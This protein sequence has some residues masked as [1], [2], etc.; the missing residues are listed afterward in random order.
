MAESAKR[1]FFLSGGPLFEISSSIGRIHDLIG[2]AVGSNIMDCKIAARCC[3]LGL[4]LG[5]LI[6]L[7]MRQYSAILTQ[8]MRNGVEKIWIKV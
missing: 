2:I 5:L 4:K 3:G 7:F 1:T 8:E 6:G